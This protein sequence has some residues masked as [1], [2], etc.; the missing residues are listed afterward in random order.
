MELSPALSPPPCRP[1]AAV[2][3]ATRWRLYRQRFHRN[4]PPAAAT[5]PRYQTGE[6]LGSQLMARATRCPHLSS[7]HPLPVAGCAHILAVY[8]PHPPRRALALIN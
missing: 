8:P 1:L 5:V 6:E 3:G 2:L 7:S 4:H